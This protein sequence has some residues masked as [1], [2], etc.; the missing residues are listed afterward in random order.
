MIRYVVS[1]PG[2]ISK[3]TLQLIRDQLSDAVGT[4]RWR[5]VILQNGGT[6]KDLRHGRVPSVRVRN[7][8]KA[9]VR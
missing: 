9:R 1:F 6:I 7:A 4:P 2:N 8:Q 5:D 3:E